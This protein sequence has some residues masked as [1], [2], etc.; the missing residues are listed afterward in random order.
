[1]KWVLLFLFSTAGFSSSVFDAKFGG[2]LKLGEEFHSEY[3][4][5]GELVIKAV[6]LDGTKVLAQTQFKNPRF[7]QAFV[8][9]PKHSIPPGMPLKKPFVLEANLLSGKT[10]YSGKISTKNVKGEGRD[11]VELTL[12]Q[13]NVIP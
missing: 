6:S 5:S 1:M 2:T 8:L 4:D 7:P 9:T 13:K 11:D 10:N 12:S 3:F